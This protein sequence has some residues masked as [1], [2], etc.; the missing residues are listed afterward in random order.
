MSEQ[1][2]NVNGITSMLRDIADRIDNSIMLE[3]LNNCNNCGAKD[4]PY[5]P[6]Q[7]QI[8]R[9]NCPLWVARE[10]VPV[11]QAPAIEEASAESTPSHSDNSGE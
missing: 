5:I 1:Y 7:G 2:I 11:E 10:Q 3:K 8:V 6:E 9:I 4:C